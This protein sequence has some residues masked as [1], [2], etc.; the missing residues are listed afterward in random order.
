MGYTGATPEA[1]E[2]AII[3]KLEADP[4]LSGYVKTVDRLPW[5]RLEE[6][7]KLVYNYPALLVSY[8][9]GDDL[10]DQTAVLDHVGVFSVVCVDRNLRTP[11]A[12]ATGGTQSEKGVYDLL[13]DVLNALHFEEL[14]VDGFISMKSLGADPV[15]ADDR[16]IVFARDFE[17]RWRLQYTP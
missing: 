9:G 1:I 13:K 10:T 3:G 5:D 14:A 6:L 2:D 16:V 7:E 17:V 4:T 12:A 8:S 15:A 11:S